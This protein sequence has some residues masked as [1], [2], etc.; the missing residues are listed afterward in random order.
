MNST[1]LAN[2]KVELLNLFVAAAFIISMTAVDRVA[3]ETVESSHIRQG[4]FATCFVNENDGWAVGDLGRIFHTVDGA[5]TWEIQSAGTKRPFVSIA[6]LD[7]NTAWIAAGR[8]DCKHHGWRQDVEGAGVG[9]RSPDLV[10]PVQRSTAGDR[11][12]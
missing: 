4:L 6:C 12:R 8:R 5:K 1:L 3:A 10:D 9:N 11:R 7:P 2:K